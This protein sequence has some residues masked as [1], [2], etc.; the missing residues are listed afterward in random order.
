MTR[1]GAGIQALC[2]TALWAG[3]MALVWWIAGRATGSSPGRATLGAGAMLAA[4]VLLVSI[5][6]PAL[7]GRAPDVIPP[8][9]R[10]ALDRFDADA[11]PVVLLFDP[12]RLVSATEVPGLMPFVATPGLRRAPQ[13]VRVLL[14]MR[15]ALP[16][17]RYRVEFTPRPDMTLEGLVGLQIGRLG[18]P[19]VRPPAIGAVD[20]PPVDL[21]LVSHNHYDHLQPTSLG[22]FEE[23]AS[24]VA[25]LGLRH[26]IA[27]GFR[28]KTRVAQSVQELDW[29]QRIRV[30]DAEVTCVPAQ[31]FSARTPWDRDV[32]RLDT[33][34][35][36]G[37]MELA[38]EPT[39]V[40][41]IGQH[42]RDEPGSGRHLRRT[43]S[44]D[45]AGARIAAGEETAARGRADG[46]LHVAAL[47][48]D[49]RADETV[50]GRCD[51]PRMAEGGDRVPALLVRAEPEDVRRRLGH[52]R[53][54]APA[55]A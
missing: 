15:L 3:I 34:V 49:A 38:D 28:R 24:F 6:A 40:A 20:L 32:T 35:G 30:G 9:H 48:G 39:S 1:L 19:R 41:G 36:R 4:A 16:A 22:L 52:A 27:S 46:C 23:R 31:H 53:S 44:R 17:G 37:Q 45:P 54:L 21:V 11:R 55:Q 25:P 7:S 29:W 42:G 13:P 14:N 5:A 26:Q 51:R 50:K 43:V 33:A 8:A 2:L 18:P 47:E 10:D 12:I